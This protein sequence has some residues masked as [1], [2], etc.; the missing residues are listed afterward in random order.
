MKLH[1]TILGEGTPFLILHGFLGMSDN[2]KTLG[3]SISEKG[4]EVHLIDQR[5]HGK[6]PH[7]DD[8]NYNLLAEDIQDYCKEKN[9]E[10]IILLGHSMGG[11]TAMLTAFMNSELVE[12]LIVVDIAPKYYAPHH[13]EILDGLTA[14][15]EATITSRGDAEDFLEEFV[16]DK[17]TRLFLLK[18]LYWETKEKLALKLNLKV[19]KE[20]IE[21]LGAALPVQY[22]YDKPTLFIKGG[23]SRYIKEEDWK[24]IKEQFSKAELVTIPGAGHWVHSEKRKDFLKALMDFLE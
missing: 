9:L 19:L 23:N 12:K 11:K 10:R 4:Y 3:N 2:W 24:A 1:S 7:S 21:D 8:F 15:D 17:P 22:T 16:P 14:L 20:N 5:N 18:N 6:S 13:Q